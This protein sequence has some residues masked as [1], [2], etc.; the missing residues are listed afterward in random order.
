M[1]LEL[2][3]ACLSPEELKKISK[4]NTKVF[5]FSLFVFENINSLEKFSA[6][7]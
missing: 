7:N 1:F 5:M 2:L 6:K 4:S 3:V